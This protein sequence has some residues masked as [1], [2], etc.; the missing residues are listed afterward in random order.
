MKNTQLTFV[1]QRKI[2]VTLR[3]VHD[4]PLNAD[5]YISLTAAPFPY[6][7]KGGGL[8]FTANGNHQEQSEVAEL[9]PDHPTL[10][11]Y[12]TKRD[13]VYYGKPDSPFIDTVIFQRDGEVYTRHF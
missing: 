4:G 2:S 3:L 9:T 11:S 13:G 6:D 5:D 7:N 12:W 1:L 10:L 8:W